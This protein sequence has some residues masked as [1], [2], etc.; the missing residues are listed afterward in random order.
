[1]LSDT[2]GN[3][4]LHLMAMGTIRDA[5]YDFI[6]ALV[7]KYPVRLT[8]N[9]DNKTPLNIIKQTQAKPMTLRGQPNYK[10][11]LWEYFEEKLSKDPSFQDSD[12]NEDIHEAVIR[13]SLD[14][15][16]DVLDRLDMNDGKSLPRIMEKLEERNYEGKT[17]L[18]LAIEHER[19]EITKHIIEN[20]SDVD[21][22]K[23]DIKDGN[24]ALH[25]ACLKEDTHIVKFIFDR[26]PRLCLK[27]N[28]YGQSPIHIATQRKN[29][30]ILKIFESFKAQCLQLKDC[31]G[32]NPLFYAAREGDAEIF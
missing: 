21:L 8:R 4:M 15:V 16:I 30:S 2:Q 29:I 5:E 11:K 18:M 26:R 9:Q 10:K 23:Q 24:S 17:A 13:G 14:E 25:I 19:D 32:E 1:M 3:T 6:K 31:S 27:P 20:Y 28:Y 7:E 12:K 22:E